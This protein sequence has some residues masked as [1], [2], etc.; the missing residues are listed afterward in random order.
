MARTKHTD[1]FWDHLG[2]AASLVKKLATA[3]G[4]VPNS[5][6]LSRI[7]ALPRRHFDPP[8]A[9]DVTPLFRKPGGTMEFWP[10]QSLALVEAAEANGLF[11]PIGCGGGKSLIT[12]TLPE[13]MDS[14]KSVLLVPP[15]LKKKTLWEIEYVYG[16]HFNLPMDRL[17]IIAYSQLSSARHAD[18]LE[19]IEPDLIIADECHALRHRSS[20]RTKRF[21]RYMKEMPGTRFAGLSGTITNRSLTD[22]AHL[23]E[24]SHKKNSVLPAGYREVRD[25]AGAIDVDPPNPMK[26]GALMQ[27]CKPGENVRHGY[28]RRFV[29]TLGIV[30]TKETETAASL[31]FR[32][33]QRLFPQPVAHALGRLSE[34]WRI[35][36]EEIESA[37]HYARVRQQLA[38]G[39]YTR[40][41]WPDT[42]SERQR[43]G[44]LDARAE[45]HKEVRTKLKQ[46]RKG[47]DSPLLLRQAADRFLR[48]STNGRVGDPP[49]T[50]WDS[51]FWA[52][53]K[54][55]KSQIDQPPT[56]AVWVS[57]YMVD[58]VQRWADEKL[59]PSIIWYDHLP[60]GELLTERTGWP[61]YGAGTDAT[62]AREEIIVCSMRTQGEG[63]NLQHYARN[64]FTTVPQ[65]GTRVEQ[66]TSRT[67]RPGQLADEVWVDW[68]GLEDDLDIVIEDSRYILDT[69]GTKHR[70]LCARLL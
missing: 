6:E 13:A 2:D 53:W 21:M 47:F 1:E 46:S 31:I 10:L 19:R 25:W 66:T 12:L 16:L 50:S 70:I 33:R 65:N 35:G 32:R 54:M 22:Y 38:C 37:L 59:E 45:W 9:F 62:Q 30:T 41:V 7:L 40:W 63:K 69:T 11:A 60:L 26:P 18:I 29:D 68:F 15:A 17:I 4:S 8:K 57:D 67:H 64:L 42:V 58:L 34:T 44:W 5:A 51:K 27:L 28:R 56:E 36:T 3:R 43:Q 61:H 48:W 39:F 14:K 20:A 23:M 52:A 49:K 55:W 24:L